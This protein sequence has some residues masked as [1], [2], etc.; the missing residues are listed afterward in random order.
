MR[1]RATKVAILGAGEVASG[2]ALRLH[3]CGF[4]LLLTEVEEPRAIRRLVAFSEAVFDGRAA[5]EEAR[6]AR[7]VSLA[8]ADAARERGEIPVLVDSEGRVWPAWNPDVLVDARMLKGSHGL[9]R[10]SAPL[11]IGLGPGFT[12]GGD[13]H[14]VIETLR[15]HEMG[16]VLANGSTAPNTG[17]PAE[18]AG[19][20]A[21]RVFRAP[22]DG[23]FNSDRRLGDLLE[24]GDEVARVGE[25]PCVTAIGGMLRGLLR[26]GLLVRA[27]EKVG[28]VD[29]RGSQVNP[30]TV[31]DR[32]LAIAGG[33][34]EAI[35]SSRPARGEGTRIP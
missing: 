10:S 9:S 1:I 30:H 13:C 16:R 6:A 3:R 7:V 20:G 22:T 34:L 4:S 26:P 5:V 14:L 21:R 32:S 19:E 12:V 31:S 11:V 25:S 15:G 27:G 2:V 29:P 18:R 23:I 17:V 8:E 24:A 33:V 35:L 28:D